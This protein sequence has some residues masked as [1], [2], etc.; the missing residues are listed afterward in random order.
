MGRRGTVRR[1]SAAE[2]RHLERWLE[3]SLGPVQERRARAI[4]LHGAGV[5]AVEIAHQVEAHVNTIYSD[6]HSFAQLGV[7]AVHQQGKRGAPPR[8]GTV[9]VQEICRLADQSPAEVGL[10]YGRWSLST[11]RKYLIGHHVL[12]RISREHLRQLIKK[13]ACS[14][15]KSSAS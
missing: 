1:P 13:G 11:L 7:R 8:I 5:S 15:A 6:L 10:G 4:V 14:T 3:D 12:K 2:V 9:A